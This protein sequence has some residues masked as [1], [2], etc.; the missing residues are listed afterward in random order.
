MKRLL[1]VTKTG[2][3]HH[4]LTG[5]QRALLYRLA[6]ETGLRW[7]ELRSL[8]KS[9]FDLDSDPPTVTLA[10]E[11]EKSRRGAVQAFSGELAA[12]LTPYLALHLP[13]ARA[14]PMRRVCGA[15]MLQRDMR[16][17]GIPIEDDQGH[18]ENLELLRL[19]NIFPEGVSFR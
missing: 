18:V 9:F 7:S 17:A 4:C 11:A 13:N 2:E 19:F 5:E 10:A 14:F 16:A 3:K 12:D 6:I 1:A 8:V 15:E